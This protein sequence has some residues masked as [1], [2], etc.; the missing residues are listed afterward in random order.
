MLHSL[1]NRAPCFRFYG[2]HWPRYSRLDCVATIHGAPSTAAS[3]LAAGAERQAM[4]PEEEEWRDIPGMPDYQVS[5]R[6]RMRSLKRQ[7]TGRILQNGHS[8][9]YC[10]VNL[11]GRTMKVHQLVLTTFVGPKPPNGECRHLD[12]DRSNNCLA[13][14][15]WGTKT[16]NM[17]D[18]VRH[19]RLP[20]TRNM[21]RGEMNPSAKLTAED[22]L[23]IRQQWPR[24]SVLVL[25]R[26]YG[27]GKSTIQHIV[28][29]ETWRHI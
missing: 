2:P 23:T 22:V 17:A 9:G 24:L 16:E 12:G 4:E 21:P 15:R 28:R 3:S 29:R 6:G 10:Q 13:N 27:V 7:T 11:N 14:L 25:S 26:Q 20:A 1:D 5:D 8:R 19:G 18:A